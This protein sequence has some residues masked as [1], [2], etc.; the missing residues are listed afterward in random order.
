MVAPVA[1]KQSML[2]IEQE[3]AAGNVPKN[4]AIRLPTRVAI[5]KVG[6]TRSC[7]DSGNVSA[8][9]TKIVQK[10]TSKHNRPI[11]AK[12]ITKVLPGMPALQSNKQMAATR[13][14]PP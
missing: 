5:A 10:L 1:A 11:T 2:K 8:I 3:M 14:H 4:G 13:K 7:A 9:A 6:S 12:D